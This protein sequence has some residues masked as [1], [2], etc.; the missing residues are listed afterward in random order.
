MKTNTRKRL[1]IIRNSLNPKKRRDLSEL[2]K[3]KLFALEE[4]QN[5]ETILLYSSFGSEVETKQIIKESMV[6]KTVLLPKAIPEEKTIKAHK[7]QNLEKDVEKGFADIMEPKSN[8]EVI[9]ENEIDLIIVPGI[10]FGE[11]GERLGY[12][13]GYYDRFL[14][15]CTGR[16]I[17]I[18]FED[19]I[20]DKIMIKEYD[21]NMHKLVTEKRVINCEI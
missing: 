15:N 13:S 14:K 11:K 19:Q 8:C 3:E 12:G 9:D 20:T 1:A 2:I 6:N 18:C 7:I 4:Y 17:G 10:A 5:A 21:V 16:F